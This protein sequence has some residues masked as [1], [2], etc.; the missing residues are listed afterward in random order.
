[1]N[2]KA[3]IITPWKVKKLT[4]LIKNDKNTIAKMVQDHAYMAI[5]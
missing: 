5:R 1:M 4:I 3:F 2:F